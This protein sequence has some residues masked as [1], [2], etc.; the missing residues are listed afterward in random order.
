MLV[1]NGL[2]TTWKG[3]NQLGNIRGIRK[4]QIM[5]GI[6]MMR[7]LGKIRRLFDLGGEKV[8]PDS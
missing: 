8:V 6:P 2:F 7:A 4:I 3:G 5:K 1:S